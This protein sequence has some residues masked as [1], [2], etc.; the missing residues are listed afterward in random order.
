[1]TLQQLLV[2]TALPSPVTGNLKLHLL[3]A[4]F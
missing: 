1:M 2:Y 4:V 3:R